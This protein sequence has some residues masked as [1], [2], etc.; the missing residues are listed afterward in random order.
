MTIAD[1]T[2]RVWEETEFPGTEK[3]LIQL[4]KE[5]GYPAYWTYSDDNLVLM[6]VVEL[7]K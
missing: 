6:Q 2:G 4:V 5:L 7:E 3:K 1:I